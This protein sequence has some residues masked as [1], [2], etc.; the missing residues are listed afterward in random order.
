ME[1]DNKRMKQ[2]FQKIISS[3]EGQ[4]LIKMLSADGGAAMRDAGAALKNGDQAKAQETIAPLLKSPQ[5]QQ[6]MKALEKAL[7]HG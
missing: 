2:D 7:N 4:Q 3:P 6:L 1:Q 5:A